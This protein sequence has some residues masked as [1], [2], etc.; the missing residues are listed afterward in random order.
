ME[1]AGPLHPL[2]K[3]MMLQGLISRLIYI[4]IYIYVPAGSAAVVRVL[5]LTLAY[6]EKGTMKAG[7][8]V[9]CNADAVWGRMNEI[10]QEN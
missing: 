5:P 8:H 3:A 2:L 4:Y 1:L 9:V 6:V 10:L 7:S